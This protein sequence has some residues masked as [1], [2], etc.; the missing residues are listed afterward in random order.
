M[1]SNNTVGIIVVGLVAFLAIVVT[2]KWLLDSHRHHRRRTEIVDVD[3]QTQQ[4][5]PQTVV[6]QQTQ[7]PVIVLPGGGPY[8][9]HY[10]QYHRNQ[11]FWRGYNDGWNNLSSSLVT[12]A[13]LRGY[14]IGAHDRR[15]GRHYYYDRYYPPGFS[16]T[17]PGFR[18][19]I[20]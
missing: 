9:Y 2:G 5:L 20:R 13:Y 6:P 1:N 11:E 8:P 10:P 16:L 19:N 14:E 18:L 3:P 7:P 12:P 17:L 15:L 4:Q